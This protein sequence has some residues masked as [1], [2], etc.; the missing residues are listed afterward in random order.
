MGFSEYVGGTPP[1]G[2]VVVPF[3][4][5]MMMRHTW[6]KKNTQAMMPKKAA[7]RSLYWLPGS[8]MSMPLKT[9]WD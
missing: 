3:L 7:A 5:S 2:P 1:A 9:W 6:S 4:R 8:R